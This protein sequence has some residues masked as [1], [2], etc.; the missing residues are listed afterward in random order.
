MCFRQAASRIG[1]GLFLILWIAGSA[2][3]EPIA[4]SI[5]G[6]ASGS[7]GG[8]PFSDTPYLI[9]IAADTDN[10]YAPVPGVVAVS[11]DTATVFL[12]AFGLATITDDTVFFVSNAGGG[13][14][15]SKDPGLDI[16]DLACD[17]D[18][19][20]WDLTTLFGPISDPSPVVQ[21]EDVETD[22]GT[23]IF[24]STY[25]GATM[26][27]VVAAT[28]PAVPSLA[29]LGVALLAG[30]LCLGGLNRLRC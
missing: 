7:I 14:G 12:G 20:T 29:P 23:L 2:V 9:E 21:G 4:I 10:V 15:F 16:I 30:L 6:L 24:T 1:I 26:T 3:G 8:I 18:C 19:S 17:L 22:L 13:V 27:A 28:P 11:S 25:L 5:E